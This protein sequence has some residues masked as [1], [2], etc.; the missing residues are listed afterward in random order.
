LSRRRVFGNI[1]PFLIE[2][3]EIDIIGEMTV[4]LTA[5]SGNACGARI[6]EMLPQALRRLF[7]DRASTIAPFFCRGSA[8]KVPATN[9]SP[10][11]TTAW[12]W[13]AGVCR[14][15]RR[16]DNLPAI[17]SAPCPRKRIDRG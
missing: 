5:L 10:A 1:S 8:G 14:R 7:L 11:H 16:S 12:L 3:G 4:A 6:A 13:L 17:R 15:L 9:T 2:A